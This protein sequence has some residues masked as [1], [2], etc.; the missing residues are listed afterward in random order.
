[1]TG[2]VLSQPLFLYEAI[3]LKAFTFSVDMLLVQYYINK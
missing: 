2:I 1:M 3:I